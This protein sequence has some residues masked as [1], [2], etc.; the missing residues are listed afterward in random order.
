MHG[1]SLP[2]EGGTLGMSIPSLSVPEGGCA[3]GHRPVVLRASSVG[4]LSGLGNKSVWRG[5]KRPHWKLKAQVSWWSRE[6]HH[7]RVQ[8]TPIFLVIFKLTK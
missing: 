4:S 3:E 6:N 7:P 2:Y 1:H 8:R 5:G